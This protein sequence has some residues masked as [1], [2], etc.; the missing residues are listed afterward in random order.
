VL[1]FAFNT[2]G[3]RRLEAR[4]AVANGRGNGALR[5]VGATRESVLLASL[6]KNG[7]YFDQGL[8]TI[9]DRDWR[10]TRVL[11]STRVH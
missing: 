4:A 8:W 2:V 5:K 11:H 6:E 9:L 3:A 10:R 7:E 1:E